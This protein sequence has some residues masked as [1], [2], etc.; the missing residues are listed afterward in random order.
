MVLDALVHKIWSLLKSNITTPGNE[1]KGEDVG[2]RRDNTL[3]FPQG[4]RFLDYRENK[5]L[6]GIQYLDMSEGKNY[7]KSVY[8]NEMNNK[9]D[10][11]AQAS[12]ETMALNQQVIEGF[13][14]KPCVDR[15]AEYYRRESTQ[16]KS[17]QLAEENRFYCLTG[18]DTSLSEMN[19]YQAKK[20]SYNQYTKPTDNGI[21]PWELQNMSVKT[22]PDI[23]C[24]MDL[25]SSDDRDILHK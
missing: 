7:D 19:T 22:S 5:N 13:T 1:E 3:S 8:I 25:L 10:K 12:N 17:V 23:L 15:D 24:D 9:K 2:V 11:L 6:R 21:H 18:K 20:I 4:A 14:N 16:N